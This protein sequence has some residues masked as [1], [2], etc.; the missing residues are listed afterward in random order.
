MNYSLEKVAADIKDK[1]EN[2]RKLQVQ[3]QAI[4]SM[5]TQA[6]ELALALGNTVDML[7][8]CM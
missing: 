8:I 6:D 7:R 2:F 5:L 1:E 4:P 3:L